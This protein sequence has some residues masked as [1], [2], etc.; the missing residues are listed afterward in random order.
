MDG[1]ER[2]KQTNPAQ[3]YGLDPAAEFSDVT[4][5]PDLADRLSA[6]YGGDIGSLDAFTGA[7]A[8]STHV[9]A[10]AGGVFGGLLFEAWSDQLVR[11]ITGDRWGRWW[12]G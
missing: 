5:D 11:S 7:L 1:A 12:V 4:P 10:S 6:A 2:M 3:A 8:E 9:S